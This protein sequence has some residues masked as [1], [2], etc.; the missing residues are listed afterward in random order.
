MEIRQM[1]YAGYTQRWHLLWNLPSTARS[2]QQNKPTAMG[3]SKMTQNWLW[4]RFL[5]NWKL[6]LLFHSL[7]LQV[8]TTWH[9]K[10]SWQKVGSDANTTHRCFSV[11]CARTVRREFRLKLSFHCFSVTYDDFNDSLFDLNLSF[12]WVFIL[13]SMRITLLR[14]TECVLL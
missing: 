6:L 12:S 13:R 3:G 9:V 4:G 5:L 8:Q 14:R 10:A 7:A 2:G 1:L 11:W